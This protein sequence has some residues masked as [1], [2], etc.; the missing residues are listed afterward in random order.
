MARYQPSSDHL[1]HRAIGKPQQASLR[2]RLSRLAQLLAAQL[3][4]RLRYVGNI[5]GA[6]NL[7]VKRTHDARRALLTAPAA[8]RRSCAQLGPLSE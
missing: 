6:V 7:V 5:A 1:D 8:R 4:G 2:G 3:S